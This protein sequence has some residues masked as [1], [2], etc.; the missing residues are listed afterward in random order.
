[1]VATIVRDDVVDSVLAGGVLDLVVAWLVAAALDDAGCG[2][3]VGLLPADVGLLP[4]V[5][6]LLATVV[7]LLPADVGLLL[8]VVGDESA[9][10][11]GGEGLVGIEPADEAREFLEVVV[12][13]DCCWSLDAALFPAELAGAVLGLA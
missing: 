2:E 6:G 11:E 3:V 13:L 7:G 5:V 10:L 4:A 1:M 8:A 12:M 9:G